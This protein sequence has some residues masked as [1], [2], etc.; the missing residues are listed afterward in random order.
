MVIGRKE[1]SA[2]VCKYKRKGIKECISMRFI[3]SW[4]PL[5]LHSYSSVD[6]ALTSGSF[7]IMW[8]FPTGSVCVHAATFKEDQEVQTQ[9]EQT[10]LSFGYKSWSGVVSPSSKQ[11]RK[12]VALKQPEWKYIK[13]MSCQNVND[14][15]EVIIMY[16]PTMNIT[17]CM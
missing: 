4:S 6:L 13:L 9:R 17:F 5:A 7:V 1:Q 15:L 12:P 2:G 3:N 16:L 14:S 8:H 10:T 11:A